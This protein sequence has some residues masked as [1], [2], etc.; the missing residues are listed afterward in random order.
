VTGQ[1][2]NLLNIDSRSSILD[3]LRFFGIMKVFV[4]GSGGREHALVWSLARSPHV[5][6]IYLA[7]ANAGDYSANKTITGIDEAERL[8]GV[9]VFH[10]GTKINA[11]GEIETAGGRGLGV[12]ARA[13]TLGESTSRAYEAGGKIRFDGMQ[14]R[15][16]TSAHR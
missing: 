10:A 9:V 5:K 4:I 14:Y 3:L 8:S 16:D 11:D 1:F 6:Q 2:T 13:A 7:T 15:K 12:T